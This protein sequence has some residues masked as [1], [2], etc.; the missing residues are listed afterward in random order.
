MFQGQQ[1]VEEYI[2]IRFIPFITLS[3]CY[4]CYTSIHFPIVFRLTGQAMSV[5]IWLVDVHPDNCIE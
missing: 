5:Y 4:D 3:L 2:E 1:N